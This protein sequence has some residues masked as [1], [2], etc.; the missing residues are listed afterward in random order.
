MG[1]DHELE[2]AVMQLSVEMV[3]LGTIGKPPAADFTTW[4]AELSLQQLWRKSPLVWWT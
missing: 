3:G 4:Q 1:K 2:I